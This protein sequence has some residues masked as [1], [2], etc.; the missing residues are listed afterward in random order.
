MRDVAKKQLFLQ[1][2]IHSV[3]ANGGSVGLPELAS[4]ACLGLLL[5]GTFVLPRSSPAV[6]YGAGLRK[7]ET[8]FCAEPN[9]YVHVLY[10][11]LSPE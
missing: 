8:L 10:A 9:G 1:R 6:C 3:I 11:L 4:A 2:V 7:L 5:M